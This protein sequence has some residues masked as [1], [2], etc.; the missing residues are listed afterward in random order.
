MLGQRVLQF[1]ELANELTDLLVFRGLG[2]VKG[3][4]ATGGH[5]WYGRYLRLK[6]YAAVLQFS[7]LHWSKWGKSPLWLG[8]KGEDWKRSAKVRDAL[9]QS[10]IK[11]QEYDDREYCFIPILLT[12]GVEKEKVIADAL[13]QLSHIVEALPPPISALISEPP[14]SEMM[15][16]G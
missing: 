2:D 16:A 10:S 5:G 13:A 8:I 14:A 11:F 15:P 1:G 9:V 6:G 4:R 3:L 7:A 12:T